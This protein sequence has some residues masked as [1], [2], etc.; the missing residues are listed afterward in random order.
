M[1]KLI[2]LLAMSIISLT[3][4]AGVYSPWQ[5]SY[6][7]ANKTN[8]ND[9][10]QSNYYEP[11]TSF[12]EVFYDL[13][14]EIFNCTSNSSVSTACIWMDQPGADYYGTII[15]H[16]DEGLPNPSNNRILGSMTTFSHDGHS[17]PL[18]GTFWASSEVSIVTSEASNAYGFARAKYR[19]Y[20]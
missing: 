9:E 18:R 12:V 14:A 16:K 4:T 17:H 8:L 20:Y 10:D 3:M 13:E 15:I 5:E 1:K 6:S 11:T 2:L 19:L 7:Y